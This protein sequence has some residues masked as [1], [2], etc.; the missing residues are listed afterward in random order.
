MKSKKHQSTNCTNFDPD[1]VLT[2][3]ERRLVEQSIINR[4]LGKLTT[5]EEIKNV[6]RTNRLKSQK[7]SLKMQ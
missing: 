3:E 4:R 5:L 2:L 7:F 1:T 6:R